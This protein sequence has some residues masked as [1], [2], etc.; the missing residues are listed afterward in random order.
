LHINNNGL[1]DVNN[2]A[3]GKNTNSTKTDK[4]KEVEN[5][6]D[7]TIAPKKETFSLNSKS[8]KKDEDEKIKKKKCC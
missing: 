8:K 1:D 2:V 7:S 6:K 3:L 5:I 4:T